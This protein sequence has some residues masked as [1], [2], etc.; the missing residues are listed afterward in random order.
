MGLFGKK[1]KM[2]LTLPVTGAT[3]GATSG[4]NVQANNNGDDENLSPIEA[5][6]KKLREQQAKARNAQPKSLFQ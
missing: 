5:F 1:S 6:R 2:P 4:V 3:S